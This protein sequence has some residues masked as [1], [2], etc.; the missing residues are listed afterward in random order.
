MASYLLQIGKSGAMAARAALELTGQNIANSGNADYVRR[1]L[2]L[3]DMTPT[4][5]VAYHQATVA[6]SGVRVDRVA[7]SDATILFAQ[8][9]QAGS[10]LARATAE[11]SGL[12]EAERSVEQAGIHPALVEFEAALGALRGDPLSPALRAQVLERGRVLADSVR[13]ADSGLAGAMERARFE[14]QGGIAAVNTDAG[15][16]ARLNGAL[17]RAREGTAGHAALLDRR[18][19]LLG[20]LAEQA[21][22]TVEYNARGMV[23]VR[24]GDGTGAYLVSGTAASTLAGTAQP[25]GTF[26]FSL[27]A[28]PVNM[29]GGALAGHAQ[30]LFAQRDARAGVEALATSLIAAV[31]AA[32]GSGVTPAGAPG[33][34]FFAGSGAGDMTLVLADGAGIATAPAGAG[35]Q[36]RSTANLDTLRAALA[37][38]GGPVAEADALLNRLSQAVAGR[39]VTQ[40][41]LATVA[42]S[43]RGALQAETA[44]DLDAEAANLLRFQQAF[45]ASGRVIQ[46][47]AE[48]F[49]TIL[50]IR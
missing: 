34:P 28:A 26:A 37:G 23:D 2:S 44:V 5:Q 1:S 43:A 3:A 6:G 10:D 14:A 9:R 46:A 15:E 19:A 24:L 20:R 49:D 50:G 33:A 36:S 11:L 8:A 4:G 39:S 27:G 42:E 41:V 48:V 40:E 29:A 21:A 35:P 12:R 13:L 22:I 16:L 30:A 32:Q 25:D 47:A 18:D 7:R 45:Q 31:N 17:L 38:A